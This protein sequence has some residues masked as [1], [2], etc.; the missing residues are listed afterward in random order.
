MKILI[1]NRQ[2]KQKILMRRIRKS[3][4]QLLIRLNCL[5]KELSVVFVDDDEIRNINKAY[6]NRD[7]PTNVIAFAM[8]EGEFKDVNPSVLG[9]IIISS[10]T[11]HRD[12]LNDDIEFLDEIE[13]LLIHGLLHLLGYDHENNSVDE[14]QKM[15]RLSN[16][17]F[18]ELKGYRLFI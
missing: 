6:L 8:M 12:A 16:E 3:L 4:K 15:K 5:Q 17:L 18:F 7:Y 1:E 9:D 10:E 11:A 13:F 14:A 2:N